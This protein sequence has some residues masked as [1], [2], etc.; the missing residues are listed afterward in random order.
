[1]VSHIISDMLLISTYDISFHSFYSQLY[2]LPCCFRTSC[3]NTGSRSL[4]TFAL[5]DPSVREHASLDIYRAG[6]FPS[7]MPLEYVTIPLSLRPSFP[8][9]P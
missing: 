8:T 3:G 4:R 9:M 5:A 7:F 1:M 6:I 2:Y